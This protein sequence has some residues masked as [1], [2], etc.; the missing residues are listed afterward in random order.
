MRPIDPAFA[1]AALAT[2]AFGAVSG[3]NDSAAE[4]AVVRPAPTP[5]TTQQRVRTVVIRQAPL[6]AVETVSGLARA[7]HKATVKAETQARVVV[8][9]VERGQTVEAGDPLLE[10]DASRLELALRQAEANLTARDSDLAHAEREHRRGERLIARKAISA[11][12]RD[13]L[14]HQLERARDARALAEVARDTAR[15]NLEDARITAPFSGTVD[16]LY[17]DVGEY[18]TPGTPVAMLVD[19]SRVRVFAGVTGETAARLA[20]GHQ[21]QVRLAALGGAEFVAKLRSVSS[22][23]NERDGT[24]E[25]ELWIESPLAGVRD[26]MVASVELHDTSRDALPLAPRAGLLRRAGKPEIFVVERNG[27]G[28]VARLRGLK[29]GRSSG[30]W[31]EVLEGLEAGDRVVVDGQFALRDGTPVALEDAP[32]AN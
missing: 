18:V 3:C 25:L 15:R 5:V 17:V 24:Y 23:A 10:L 30:A 16:D 29:T 2:L 27:S 6:G 1:L 11:Q 13:D 12:Q 22:V 8:R 9:K 31:I 28:E 7:F 32:A 26:G 4:G 21:A 20:P 19:F 14:R